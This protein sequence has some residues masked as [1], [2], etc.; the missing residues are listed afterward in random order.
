VNG[1]ETARPRAGEFRRVGE[2][3]HR[4]SSNGA[5]Y[6]IYKNW[7][8]IIHGFESQLQPPPGTTSHG[9]KSQSH[10]A[11]G[12]V[13]SSMPLPVPRLRLYFLS[14]EL[15]QY[16]CTPKLCRRTPSGL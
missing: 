1:M 8:K 7:G 10:D 14:A 9:T 13:T 12:M 16:S 3:L 6:A 11:G 15:F 2:N 5:Y 4:H